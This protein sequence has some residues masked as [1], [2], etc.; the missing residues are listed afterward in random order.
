MNYCIERNATINNQKRDNVDIYDDYGLANITA[1]PRFTLV[2]KMLSSGGGLNQ[3]SFLDIGCG[4]GEFL[5]YLLDLYPKASL[6]GVDLYEK[7]YHKKGE[8]TYKVADIG[9]HG[10]PFDDDFFDIVFAGEVIEHL[11]DT[12]RFISE[13][14]RVLRP[15][16]ILILTTP[17]ASSLGNLMNWFRKT[18][19]YHCDY[20]T[21]QNGHIR[22]YSVRTICSQLS[23]HG[24]LVKE[25]ASVKSGFANVMNRLK[26][27][28][29]IAK[30]IDSIFLHLFPKRGLVLVLLSQLCAAEEHDD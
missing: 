24:F 6:Y 15:N 19:Y 1:N 5:N 2:S 13:A 7:D 23:E 12:D 4:K 17:N 28:R 11:Y 25:I 21:N 22:Y 16:G 10:I 3:K 9:E 18:Q 29:C 30:R 20:R 27:P 14:C 8:I 26:I